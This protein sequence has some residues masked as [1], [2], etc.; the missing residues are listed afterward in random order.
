M[1]NDL[2][3]LDDIGAELEDYEVSL[4][5]KTLDDFI[6]QEPLVRR[7]RGRLAAVKRR[8]GSLDHMLFTGGAGLG[9][10]SLALL[11][12]N[13]LGVSMQETTGDKLNHA[14]DLYAILKRMEPADVLFIDEIHMMPKH[15]QDAL[16]PVIE[17]YKIAIKLGRGPSA[18]L[19]TKEVPRFTLVAA[20]T[21]S[22]KLKKP[23]RDRIPFKGRLTHYSIEELTEI[24]VRSCEVKGMLI[25]EEAAK[26]VAQRSKCTPR[27]AN[28][29]VSQLKD[30]DLGNGGDGELI[31][32]PTAEGF[33]EQ[34]QVDTLGLDETEQELLRI[35]CERFSGSSVGV[36][37]LAAAIG[38]DEESLPEYEEWLLN[39]QLIM[40]NKNG[41]SATP[42]GYR[43]LKIRPPW[44]PKG[45]AFDPCN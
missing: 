36:Q 8:G 42:K 25:E 23:F 40:K 12:A 15:V 21:E 22:G 29:F 30:Y 11:M 17:D 34:E 14:G 16:L 3:L 9:K 5:P 37:N 10:T 32:V 33:F 13:E 41:R 1:S 44:M 35:L 27:K 24:V 45:W 28:G 7:L 39:Q 31:T 18:E 4:R 20:T 6:G 43:H 38:Q 26:M 19:V 2:A